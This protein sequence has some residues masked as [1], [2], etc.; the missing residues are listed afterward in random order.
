[1]HYLLFLLP[2]IFLMEIFCFGDSLTYGG[3]ESW[4]NKLLAHVEEEYEDSP[5]VFN[6]GI[7]GESSRELLERFEDEFDVRSSDGE[8]KIIIFQIGINDSQIIK[9]KNGNRVQI[10][11]FKQ[12]LE[13]L[14]FRAK[15]KTDKIFFLGLTPVIEAKTDPVDWNTNK[16]LR[17]KQ[18]RKYE[19][20]LYSFCSEKDSNFIELYDCFQKNGYAELL[21]DDGVHPNEEGNEM[22]FKAVKDRLKKENII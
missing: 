22:I 5:L 10:E 15:Q 4:A 14:W 20:K 11:E 13:N 2:I 18:V 12:N 17:T 6:L 19:D 9:T 21:K 1:M 3:S 16:A 7:P 8:E